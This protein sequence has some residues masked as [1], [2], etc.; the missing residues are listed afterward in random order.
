[1]MYI[2]INRRQARAARRLMEAMRTMY[3]EKR[4][5]IE[6]MFDQDNYL[7]ERN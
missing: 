7:E 2:C 3:G 4:E 5:F 1:M 6:D